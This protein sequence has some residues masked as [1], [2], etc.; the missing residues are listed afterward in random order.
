MLFLAAVNS[1]VQLQIKL[2]STYDVDTS[3]FVC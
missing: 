3:L 2:L 1:A